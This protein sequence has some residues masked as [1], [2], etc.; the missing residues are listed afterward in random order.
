MA[1][2]L[3]SNVTTGCGP[4]M[5]RRSLLLQIDTARQML[6]ETVA[7]RA[8]RRGFNMATI[9]FE[10][11]QRKLAEEVERKRAAAYEAHMAEL[12][13]EEAALQELLRLRREEEEAARKAAAEGNEV[14]RLE[15]ERL[16]SEL[17][18]GRAAAEAAA[19]AER[20]IIEA[21][22]AAEAAEEAVRLERLRLI[23]EKMM[24]A[25]KERGFKNMGHKWLLKARAGMARR[26]AEERAARIQL[27]MLK[28]QKEIDDE[29]D[30]ALAAGREDGASSG[31]V[32]RVDVDVEQAGRNK[33]KVHEKC[34]HYGHLTAHSRACPY[35]T[36]YD[37]TNGGEKCP[38]WACKKREGTK[39]AKAAKAT[40]HRGG[41][42]RGCGGCGRGGRGRGRGGGGAAR[43]GR[44]R[45]KKGA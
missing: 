42:G 18:A 10:E 24:K 36:H 3:L 40:Q 6:A 45:R 1:L 30:K 32:L 21:A 7:K 2:L 13:K 25:A 4:Q 11:A 43:I 39:A 31:D 19:A 34:G 17:E 8:M 27:K 12:A 44:K 14:D 29:Y 23:E 38:C 16:L 41:R 15:H 33:E 22:E 37:G 28:L 20:A 9:L 35:N 5:R 26:E